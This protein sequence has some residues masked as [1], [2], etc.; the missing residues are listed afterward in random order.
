MRSTE[1]LTNDRIA[2]VVPNNDL[3]SQP[4][5]NW[6]RGE[7]FLRVRVSVGVAYGSDPARV[8]D[9]LLEAARSVPAALQD[10]PPSVR[11][12]AFGDSAIQFTLLA[13]TRELLHRRGEF[14]SRL[15]FAVHDALEKH[16]ITIPFPQR[17]LHLRSAVPLPIERPTPQGMS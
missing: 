10:P 1:I 14:T 2:V 9:A 7:D 15:N 13:Y 5:I 3:T 6:S 4:I 16:G 8:R 11:L 12:D 17:D